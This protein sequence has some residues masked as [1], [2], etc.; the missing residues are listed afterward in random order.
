MNWQKA[1]MK[2]LVQ[3]LLALKDAAEARRFLRDLMT[4]S[5]LTD[6]AKRLD[7]ARMLAEGVPYQRIQEE[8]GFSTTTIARVSRWLQ[9]G[10]GGYGLVLAR[11]H[12]HAPIS[13]ERGLR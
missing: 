10:E 6:M 9:E 4:E 7:T 11:A 3:A 1:D 5:E 13:R 2:Q 12:H 8:T